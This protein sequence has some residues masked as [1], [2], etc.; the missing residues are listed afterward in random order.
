[1]EAVPAHRP[2]ERRFFSLFLRYWL[3]VMAYVTV[4]LWL[5][6]QPYLQPPLHFRNSDKV[7]HI[8]EYSVLGFLLARA[9]RSTMRIRFALGA[10]MIALAM[11]IAIGAGDEF[12]QSFVPGRDSSVFDLLA[13]SIGLALAQIA[14]L[15]IARD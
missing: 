8:L 9:W 1:M 6:S 13:D 5:S 11:G 10:A 4:I 3:P 2:P 14:Y 15:L 12:Y 7:A